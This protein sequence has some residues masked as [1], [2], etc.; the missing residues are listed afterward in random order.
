M[1]IVYAIEMFLVICCLWRISSKLSAIA[2]EMREDDEGE[3]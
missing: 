1:P 3:E 2:R